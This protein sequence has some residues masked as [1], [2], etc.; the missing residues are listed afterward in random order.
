MDSNCTDKALDAATEQYINVFK[1]GYKGFFEV[2]KAVT[3]V[4]ESAVNQWEK[5][6]GKF[7]EEE[8]SLNAK[9]KEAERKVAEESAQEKQA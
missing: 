5:D 7:T 8:E 1:A 9:F 2:V 6:Q 4:V 3:P